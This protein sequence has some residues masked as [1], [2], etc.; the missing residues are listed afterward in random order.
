M[1]RRK[2]LPKLLRESR[3]LA[4]KTQIQISRE[5]KMNRPQYISNIERGISSIS[6]K[7]IFKWSKVYECSTIDIID[8]ITK[9]YRD[10]LCSLVSIDSMK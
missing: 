2:H 9:D 6:P 4:R 3:S 7:C 1:Y 8:A 10:Y 5:L